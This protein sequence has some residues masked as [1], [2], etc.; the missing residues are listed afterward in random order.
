MPLSQS[1]WQPPPL[2][3][4]SYK[5][6]DHR[7]VLAFPECTIIGEDSFVITSR[8]FG[9]GSCLQCAFQRLVHGPFLESI[10]LFSSWKQDS[11]YHACSSA[12]WQASRSLLYK[13]GCMLR[14]SLR[15]WIRWVRHISWTSTELYSFEQGTWLTNL[16]SLRDFF[17]SVKAGATH[18]RENLPLSLLR[19]PACL[20]CRYAALLSID[21]DFFV[22][23]SNSDVV[24]LEVGHVLISGDKSASRQWSRVGTSNIILDFYSG[25]CLVRWIIGRIGNVGREMVKKLDYKWY[26]DQ[27]YFQKPARKFWCC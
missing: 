5:P 11:L 1:I 16:M 23:S 19:I 20:A 15:L 25:N 7:R 26:H 13:A 12:A 2:H 3:P 9:V 22:L 14:H 6:P 27:W 18:V 4:F 8:Q 10:M 24:I 17:S 21:C